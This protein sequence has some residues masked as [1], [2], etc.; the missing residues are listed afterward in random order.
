MQDVTCRH[1]SEN[2]MRDIPIYDRKNMGL[3]DWLL[4]IEK[5]ASLTH[6]QEYKLATTD[7][8]SKTYKMLKR[9]GNNTDW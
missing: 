2:L 4:H 9:L 3:A 8:T 6:I 7:S 5:V 1:E